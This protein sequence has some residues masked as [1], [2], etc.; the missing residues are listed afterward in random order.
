[1]MRK[2]EEEISKLNEYEKKWKIN[3]N[4]NKFKV[5]PISK[6]KQ[7]PLIVNGEIIPYN[8]NGKVL[9]LQISTRRIT[10][11]VKNII[12]LA[13]QSLIKLA[14]FSELEIKKNYIYTSL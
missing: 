10:T 7:P 9:G 6:I 14:I 1:M 3:T 5:I 12:N 13:K 4:K 8:S 11:H 2:T